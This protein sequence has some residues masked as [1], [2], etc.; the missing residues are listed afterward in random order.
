MMNFNSMVL[1]IFIFAIHYES[2]YDSWQRNLQKPVELYW[3][4]IAAI[5][6]I[7]RKQKINEKVHIQFKNLT[8]LL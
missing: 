1:F 8:I 5:C 7:N 2:I 3:D 6:T 4:K